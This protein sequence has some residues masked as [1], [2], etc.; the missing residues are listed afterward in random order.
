MRSR[1]LLISKRAVRDI[2]EKACLEAYI[3]QEV[4]LKDISTMNKVIGTSNT[5]VYLAITYSVSDLMYSRYRHYLEDGR[6]VAVKVLRWTSKNSA[7]VMI[8]ITTAIV[9]EHENIIKTH[10]VYLKGQLTKICYCLFL[11]GGMPK[12]TM[13]LPDI[14]II[15]L[16]IW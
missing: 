13:T 6:K 16:A 15:I 5:E 3:L 10:G 7:E 1:Q 12:S 11:H 8:E 14:S 9:A 2:A 4:K